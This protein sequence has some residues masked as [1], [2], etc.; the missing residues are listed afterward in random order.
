M[1][2]DR[3]QPKLQ[4]LNWNWI[5][6]ISAALSE[7]MRLAS[8]RSMKPA[9]TQ[10]GLIQPCGYRSAGLERRRRSLRS[11][12]LGQYPSGACS[13]KTMRLIKGSA[14]RGTYSCRL[15]KKVSSTRCSLV[16]ILCGP[17]SLKSVP[18]SLAVTSDA[19]TRSGSLAASIRAAMLTVP[20]HTS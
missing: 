20:P 12:N 14:A 6:F 4:R 5:T 13:Q 19:N 8:R 16:S 18:S 10:L 11:R 15:T 3:S 7:C 2:L 9:G 1:L 17:S